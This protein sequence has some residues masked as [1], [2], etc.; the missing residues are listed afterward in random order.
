MNALLA[1]GASIP[2]IAEAANLPVKTIYGVRRRKWVQGET[3]SAILAVEHADAP[4]PS[5]LVPILVPSRMVQALAAIGWSLTD[6]AREL[7]CIVQQVARIAHAT[8][9]TV[10]DRRAQAVRAMF[11]RLCGTPG[12]S[13][14]ARTESVRRQWRP[15]LAWDDI[16]DPDAGLARDEV[17]EAEIDEVAVER[18][19]A[20]E[21]LEL[22]DA[23]VV[24]VLRMGAGRGLTVSALAA[25]LG[26][27]YFTANKLLGVEKTPRKLMQERVEAELL[28][29]PN[30]PDSTIAALLDVH[31]QTVTRARAR[32]AKS[33]AL[34]AA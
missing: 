20:G 16:D 28:R 21:R 15:P 2:G 13:K 10:T 12:P 19:L 7:G 17:D 30:R 26:I 18:A 25:Q 14:R 32:L 6:Q 29:A 22:T 4:L 34:V 3:A 9:P 8:Q 11:E 23:E 5:G 1:D 27:N 31:H 24:V 33:G